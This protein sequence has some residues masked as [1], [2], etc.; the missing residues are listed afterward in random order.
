MPFAHLDERLHPKGTAGGHQLGEFGGREDSNDEQCGVCA[1][2][3]RLEQ[4]VR[5]DDKVLAQHADA[6]REARRLER[7]AHRGEVLERALEPRRLGED[8]DG[9]RAGHRVREGL[10]RR[11]GVGRDV[12]LGGRGPLH[13]CQQ[14]HRRR[15]AK[16]GAEVERRRACRDASAQLSRRDAVQRLRHVKTALPHDLVQD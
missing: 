3:P 6:G 15:A 5:V 12:A 13:L 4:L 8:G 10:L 2:G 16:R 7:G 9:A 1:V 11:V 14:A